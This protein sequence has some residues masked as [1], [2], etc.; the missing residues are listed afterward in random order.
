MKRL[1]YL[2]TLLAT[3]AFAICGVASADD[4]AITNKSMSK[5]I[6][7][8]TFGQEILDGVK[9]GDGNFIT[10]PKT[11][12]AEHAFADF[13][14]FYVPSQASS[15]LVEPVAYCNID[16]EPEPGEDCTNPVETLAVA[17]P[18]VNV[19]IYGPQ[20]DVHGTAF[21]HRWFDT[22]AAVSLDDGET[23]KKTNLSESADLSSFNIDG[24]CR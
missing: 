23:F 7:L 16:N 17:K 11:P 9:D 21:A 5:T 13:M 12:E 19:F 22:Y 2:T 3:S 24:S 10:P 1:R 18:L 15:G 20:Y 6:Q 14:K 4:G 8:P